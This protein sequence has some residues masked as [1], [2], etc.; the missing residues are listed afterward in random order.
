[1]NIYIHVSSARTCPSWF[2]IYAYRGKDAFA[3]GIAWNDDAE[4]V[5][6][7]AKCTTSA[8]PSLMEHP[9]C[10][11]AHS[12]HIHELLHP[13]MGLARLQLKMRT[14]I[15]K[16]LRLL[17]LRDRIEGIC[18]IGLISLAVTL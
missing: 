18:T 3:G 15:H 17:I 7:H 9:N 10:S 14:E 6:T 5:H 16:N 1:M 12:I 13:D 4:L 11:E 2:L 8:I